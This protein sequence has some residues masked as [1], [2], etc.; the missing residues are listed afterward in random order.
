MIVAFTGHR[1]DKLGGYNNNPIQDYVKRK[2][3]EKLEEIKPD[4]T[5]VGGALGVDTWAAFISSELNIPFTLAVPFLGQ[6]RMWPEK[7]IIEYNKMK[8]LADQVIIVNDGGYAAWKMQTR[9]Q[10]MVE[11]CDLLIAVWDGTAGG[12]GNC[13]K[14][15]TKI[16]KNIVRIDPRGL[17]AS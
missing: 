14:Y 5:V 4:R 11:N 8:S 1:P 7:S 13:V 10:Y 15:A 16:G 2:I 3:K 6:E 9:N 17:N 12:T